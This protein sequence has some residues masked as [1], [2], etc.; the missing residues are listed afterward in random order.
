MYGS[1]GYTDRQ[2]AQDV[3]VAARVLAREPART[4]GNGAGRPSDLA[5]AVTGA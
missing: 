5:G 1:V 4:R 3:V 2:S